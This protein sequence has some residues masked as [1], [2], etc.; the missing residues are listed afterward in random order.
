MPFPPAN[1]K[2]PGGFQE[3]AKKV[4][5][6][7]AASG[8]TKPIEDF[9]KNEGLKYDLT[10]FMTAASK[11]ST[12]GGKSPEEIVR[13]LTD[14]PDVLEDILNDLDAE[15]GNPEEVE[16]AKEPGEYDDMDMNAAIDKMSSKA[17]ANEK[18]SDSDF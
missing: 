13:I 17:K 2:K 3:A 12:T 10:A 8:K 18:D 6:E 15:G 11:N 5:G 7:A 1:D 4:V 14:E 9:L 16:E